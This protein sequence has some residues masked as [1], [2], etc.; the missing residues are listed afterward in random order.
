MPGVGHRA[1]IRS[2]GRE[3]GNRG[4]V[5]GRP[6]ID[7]RLGVRADPEIRTSL[8]RSG[9]RGRV[10]ARSNEVSSRSRIA[11]VSSTCFSPYA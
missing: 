7:H 1:G 6:G 8:L 5:A 10:A 9:P 3:V 11:T 4:V 2:P